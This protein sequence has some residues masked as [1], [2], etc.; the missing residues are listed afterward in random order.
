MWD[1]L[2]LCSYLKGDCNEAGVGL[3]SQVTSDKRKGPQVTP[4]E[5]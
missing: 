3:F 5:V 2:A 1:L 4:G